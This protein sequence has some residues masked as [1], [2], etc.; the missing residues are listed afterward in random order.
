MTPNSQT[1]R[2]LTFP[3]NL[4]THA[5]PK[6]P[7]TRQQ[8]SQVMAQA[9]Q[10]VS[11][12][13]FSED[14]PNERRRL[15]PEVE[16]VKLRSNHSRGARTSVTT[17]PLDSSPSNPLQMRVVSDCVEPDYQLY[18]DCLLAALL[19]KMT[20]MLVMMLVLLMM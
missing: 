2:Q 7:I 10:S 11:P 8:P 4:H 17:H 3:T 5:N 13:N 12:E 20:V 18:R 15:L 16:H 9:R 1:L 6:Q 19:L 14:E